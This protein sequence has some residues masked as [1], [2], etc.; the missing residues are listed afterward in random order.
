MYVPPAACCALSSRACRSP[1]SALSLRLLL[2]LP[3]AVAGTAG[4]IV[5]GATVGI[6]S[7]GTAVSAL[8]SSVVF[9]VGALEN[10]AGN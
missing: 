6:R 3:P 1:R 10:Q 9:S 4:I 7:A 2:L 5:T 8:D